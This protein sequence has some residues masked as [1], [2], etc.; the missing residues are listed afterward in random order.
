[1][2]FSEVSDSTLYESVEGMAVT[3]P[4]PENTIAAKVLL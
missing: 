3:L 1:M 2:V 4:D